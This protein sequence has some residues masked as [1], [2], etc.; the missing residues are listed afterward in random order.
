[1]L[2]PDDPDLEGGRGQA[3]LTILGKPM[4]G[5]RERLPEALPVLDVTRLDVPQRPVAPAVAAERSAHF[6]RR[7]RRCR[8]RC[9]WPAARRLQVLFVYSRLPL[10]MTSGDELTVV[11]LLEFLH[12]RGHE[13]DFV[14]LDDGRA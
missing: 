12:A 10:P 14:T 8:G 4:P 7:I 1:M 5:I 2:S 13:V 6:R 3:R 11:H 9:R